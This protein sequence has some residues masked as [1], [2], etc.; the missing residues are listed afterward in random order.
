[1]KQE[2]YVDDTRAISIRRG[3]L[4]LREERLA[5]FVFVCSR[6]RAFYYR[7]I[8]IEEKAGL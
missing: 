4:S 2:A 8:R 6:T 7:T 3:F 1:M 5:Y